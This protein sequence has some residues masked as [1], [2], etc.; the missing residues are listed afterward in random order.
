MRADGQFGVSTALLT[1]FAASGAVDS[2]LLAAHAARMLEE[3]ARSVTLF[4]TT[5]EGAS[6][7]MAERREVLRA[8]LA[9]GCAARDVILGVSAC[10]VE[11]AAAQVSDGVGAGITRFLALPPFYFKAPDEDGLFDWYRALIARAPA[12]ARFILYH[13]PQ[14]SGAPL[15]VGLVARLAAGADGRVIAIKDSSGDWDNA[16]A[17][18]AG[19]TLPVL[20]GDERLL[21][22]AVA[23]GAAGSISG[24]ANLHAAR[25]KRI[26]ETG[27][28]DG[29]LS[30]L[31][32]RIVALPVIAALKAAM[33]ERSGDPAWERLRPPLTPLAPEARAALLSAAGAPHG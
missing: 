26:V 25:L 30:A 21:H 29:A 18:I 11:D 32:D 17:L 24:V 5:G 1:P 4:G 23:I 13:I 33:A 2:A 16:Q 12:E 14:L 19:Q 20:V 27:E 6:I 10:A 7:G 8:V 28:E 9:A 31:V 15:S 22:R 3:G